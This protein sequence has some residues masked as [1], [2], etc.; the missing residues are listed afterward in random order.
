MVAANK[1]TSS[2]TIGDRLDLGEALPS[3]LGWN[4]DRRLVFISDRDGSHEIYVWDGL[5]L[6][7]ITLSP[8]T[9]DSSPALWTP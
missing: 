1:I 2:L 5:S 9:H 7:N 3:L 8:N 6:T 4:N